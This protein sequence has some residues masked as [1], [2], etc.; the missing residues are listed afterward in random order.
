MSA[1]TRLG[2]AALIVSLVSLAACSDLNTTEERTLSG[3]GLGA[4]GGAV[5]GAVTG[6][7]PL[8]GAAIG[9]AAGA[10]GGYLLDQSK[11][12]EVQ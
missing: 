8:V 6:G 11:K 4:A 2:G 10:A 1:L 12:D 9:T 5:I 3:A 7:N